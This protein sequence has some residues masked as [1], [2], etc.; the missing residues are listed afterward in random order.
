LPSAYLFSGPLGSGKRTTAEEI[1]KILLGRS[2][3]HP[4]FL[5]IEPEKN[6]IKIEA[7]RNL[8]HRLSLKPFEKDRIVVWIDDADSLTEGASN[9]LLKTL[10]EPAHYVLFLLLTTKPERVLPTIRSRCQRVNFQVA[11]DT[12]KTRL[13]EL[14]QS[15]CE[16]LA[17]VLR[18]EKPSFS[19]ASHLAESVAAQTDRLPSLFDLLRTYWRD[20]AVWQKTSD[21]GALLLPSAQEM[22]RT[23]AQRRDIGTLFSDTDLILETERAIEGNVNKMLALE[24]L[25][26][27]LIG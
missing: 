10:E 9:A 15:W 11:G 8:I 20:L 7:I 19:A 2:E 27:K 22:I 24:R 21:A 16:E 5:K 4:D 25:F 1:T 23:K 17:P 13:E 6:S 12:L 14:F 18:T 26:V 3:G